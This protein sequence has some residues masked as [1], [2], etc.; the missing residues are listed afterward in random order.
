MT[1][2]DDFQR[3]L[4][5][6]PDDWQ[7]RLRAAAWAFDNDVAKSEAAAWLD[8]S[9]AI[10]KAHGNQALRARWLMKDGKKKEA[11]AMANDAIAAGKAATPPADTAPTEKLVAEWVAAK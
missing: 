1:T 6:R 3:A 7:T 2:E 4:D 10:K 11:I 9:L 8:Q 5:A